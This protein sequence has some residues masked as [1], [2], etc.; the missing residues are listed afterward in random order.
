TGDN[1]YVIRTSYPPDVPLEMTATGDIGVYVSAILKP[2]VAKLTAPVL[3][4]SEPCTMR[5]MV[6]S[7][8]KAAGKRIIYEQASVEELEKENR[9][10]V[11]M[12][13]EMYGYFEEFGFCGDMKIVNGK[14]LGVGTEEVT[15][16]DRFV[17]EQ[18]WG[19]WFK[20]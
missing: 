10:F 2:H 11:P 16:F 7:I 17:G 19:F 3:A 4:L 9:G 1:T 15:G 20:E 8:S 12:M 5:Q 14:E 6:A 13:G 18:D